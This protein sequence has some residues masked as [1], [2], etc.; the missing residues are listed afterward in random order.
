MLRPEADPIKVMLFYTVKNLPCYIHGF[1]F[2]VELPFVNI[3]YSKI[4]SLVKRIPILI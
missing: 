4:E 2:L 1:N 3:V